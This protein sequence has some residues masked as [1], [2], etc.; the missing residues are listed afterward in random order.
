MSTMGMKSQPSRQEAMNF[1]TTIMYLAIVYFFA[2]CQ[3]ARWRH[4][5]SAGAAHYQKISRPP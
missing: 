5:P 2:V 4:P 3:S 1:K